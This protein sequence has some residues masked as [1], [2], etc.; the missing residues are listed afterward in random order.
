MLPVALDDRY[1]RH[2]L[3]TQRRDIAAFFPGFDPKEVAGR[4]AF[5]VLHGH[6]SAGVVVVHDLGD[7]IG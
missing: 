7:S 6:E 5:L 2:F 3:A 4:R 1:L